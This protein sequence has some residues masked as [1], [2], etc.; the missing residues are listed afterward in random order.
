MAELGGA[1]GPSLAPL[2]SHD[3]Y[4]TRTW[5]AENPETAKRVMR[6]VWPAYEDLQNPTEESREAVR[7]LS[8]FADLDK[9]AI[10]PC[11]GA[12][13]LTTQQ[14]SDNELHLVNYDRPSPIQF[15]F[16]ELYDLSAAEEARP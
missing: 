16:A 14:M 13:R 1:G 2:A 10:A 11:Q 7:K 12:T 6:T 8:A 3:H 5:F 4:T 9:G 15:G